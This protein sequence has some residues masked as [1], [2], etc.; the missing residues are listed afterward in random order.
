MGKYS[1]AI[2]AKLA[3]L[4]KAK[5]GSIED[6]VKDPQKELNE[7]YLEN[8]EFFVREQ[9]SK[10]MKESFAKLTP[11]KQAEINAMNLPDEE[12]WLIT[13]DAFE[14]QQGKEAAD[15]LADEIT[16]IV[17]PSD[18]NYPPQKKDYVP[19]QQEINELRVGLQTNDPQLAEKM[20]LLSQVEQD[21]ALASDE[22]LAHYNRLDSNIL[23][24]VNSRAFVEIKESID[25]FE[26]GKYA[27]KMP[28]EKADH[29]Q[30]KKYQF[31]AVSPTNCTFTVE[32]GAELAHSLKNP[33]SP[34]L[35]KDVLDITGK[36]EKNGE[37]YVVP[38]VTVLSEKSHFGHPYYWSEHGTKAYAFWPLHKA[39]I[40]LEDAVK[41]K[42]FDKIRKAQQD[43]AEQRKIADEMMQT[44]GK[45]K[46]PLCSANSNSTRGGNI[47]IKATLEGSQGR[48]AIPGE[49]MKD[50]LTHSKLNGLFMFHVFSKN[51][52]VSPEEFLNNPADAMRRGANKYIKNEGIH[53]K[54][55]G[56]RLYNS[57]SELTGPGMSET[58]YYA[59][60]G[61]AAR[62]FEAVASM[63]KDPEKRKA[64]Q[65]YGALGVAAGTIVINDYINK[66]SEL[67]KMDAAKQDRY[68]QY[69]ALL[70]EKE[71]DPI[72]L[73]DKLF[74]EDWQEAT[75]PEKLV[76]GLRAEG[77]LDFAALSERTGQIV[78]ENI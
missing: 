70:P 15:G 74:A 9:I 58:Y 24:R 47:P 4:G 78:K 64:I 43:Y 54:P 59:I 45:Y 75:D 17:S 10:K 71:F 62:A 19:I 3:T 28:Q 31:D 66:L 35:Q 42:D 30:M 40:G 63:E 57:L 32:D 61:T 14:A 37:G 46:T 29:M 8:D 33:I 27:A 23:N 16:G 39:Y 60:C 41:S 34:E 21:L 51:T 18:P 13:A 68:Y 44:V 52:G 49:Y 56:A 77:K 1:E 7:I 48:V 6:F 25:S 55:L 12:K 67:S 36:M 72:K 20:E 11:E 2:K 76:A 5:V 73:H 69:A 65:G 22:V 53:N 38:G 26:G 50:F